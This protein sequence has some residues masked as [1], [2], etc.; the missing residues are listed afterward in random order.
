MHINIVL[1][2]V[3]NL[4]NLCRLSIRKTHLTIIE[5]I[6]KVKRRRSNFDITFFFGGGG[7]LGLESA[8]C[9]FSIELI[10]YIFVADISV[11]QK[12]FEVA[13][14]FQKCFM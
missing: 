4:I 14:D 5:I 10:S 2:I 12:Q 1:S 3:Y 9:P 11:E 6:A 13:I 7:N 8:L